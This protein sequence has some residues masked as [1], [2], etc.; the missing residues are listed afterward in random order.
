MAAAWVR[1]VSAMAAMKDRSGHVIRLPAV[2]TEVL[3]CRKY[4]AQQIE[5]RFSRVTPADFAHPFKPK[6]LSIKTVRLGQ[7]VRAKQHR[8]SR[9]HLQQEFIVGCARKE[10]RS[11]ALEPQR[12]ALVTANEKWVFRRGKKYAGREVAPT[13]G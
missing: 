6:F 9:L 3:H 5:R 1:L 10:A 12:T 8:V 4:V 11:N 7:A 2:H 13:A